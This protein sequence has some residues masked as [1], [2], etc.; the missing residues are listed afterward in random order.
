MGRGRASEVLCEVMD[1]RYMDV[2]F[3][4]ENMRGWWHE[5]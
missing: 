3:R 5:C 1:D 4:P 2:E